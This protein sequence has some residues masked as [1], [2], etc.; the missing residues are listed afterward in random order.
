MAGAF[1]QSGDERTEAA[2][3]YRREE[4]RRQGKVAFSREITSVA[5]VVAAGGALYLS[6]GSLLR[7]MVTLCTRLFGVSA[8][9]MGTRD[10]VDLSWVV[11][12]SFLSMIGPIVGCAVAAGMATSVAQVGLVFSTEPVQ[13]RWDR[14]DPMR[15]LQRMFS[16]HGL[17]PAL[18]ALIQ[19]LVAAAVGW[20]FFR[21][22]WAGLPRLLEMETR[23]GI[24]LLMNLQ[25]RLLF[26]VAATFALPAALD[27]LVQRMKLER[28]LKMTRQ[29]AKEEFKLREGDPLIRARI[30]SMQ[31]RLAGRRMMDKVPKADVV[32]T[33]PTHF[34]VALQY[35]AENMP[36]PKVVAK[37]AGQVAMRIKELALRSG[38]PCVENKP[39]A[40][41]LFRKLD[42]GAEIPRELYKAVAEVLGYVYRIKGKTMKATA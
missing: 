7:E 24:V 25:I 31:R 6:G 4:F 22:R 11:V 3:P 18:K 19:T 14:L 9:E 20:Y 34:A 26:I 10:V 40:R 28:E 16:A 15:H 5:V 39:L 17:Y 13:P 32:V 33:N 36:A 12:R 30:R 27:Y 41:T 1:E 38:V 29:E 37:G 42:I 21:D 2:T 23:E 35:D 8:K